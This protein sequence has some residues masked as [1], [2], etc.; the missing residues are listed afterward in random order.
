V[1]PNYLYEINS[2][3]RTKKGWALVCKVG[4]TSIRKSYKRGEA[5]QFAELRPGDHIKM[6]VRDPRARIVSAWEEFTQRLVSYKPAILKTSE[7]D[8]RVLLDKNTPFREWL[9]VALRHEDL[10]WIPQS[11]QYPRWR[12][13]ELLNVTELGSKQNVGKRKDWR[14]YLQGEDLALVED[15]YHDDFAIWKEVTDGTDT[16][17]RRI[18]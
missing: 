14:D 5:G 4:S 11:V 8:H 6:P 12:E 18:L 1:T 15:Y 13:F 17:A 2:G 9:R 7:E 3:Q 16:R 10:H